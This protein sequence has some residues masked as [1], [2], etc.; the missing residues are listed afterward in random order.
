MSL[1]VLVG[2]YLRSRLMSTILN[3]FLL[4]LGITVIVFV[5]LVGRQLNDSAS[6]NSRGIDLVIAAKGSPLQIILCNVHHIDFP[7]G[8]INL[9]EAERIA[10]NSLVKKAIPL[11]L[12]DSYNG[13]RIVGTDTAYARLYKASLA[14]GD[15]WSRDLEVVAGSAAMR[16]LNLKVGDTFSS[17]H[18]LTTDGDAHDSHPYKLVGVL[19]P[20]GTVVDNLLLTNISSIWAV[21]SDGHETSVTT[22]GEESRL[23]PGVSAGDSTKEI[24]SVLIKYRNP[25]AAIQLPRMINAMTTMQAASPAF[26]MARIDSVF[27]VGVD[28][29]TGLS[30]V[31]ICISALSTFLA[32]YNA[33]KDRRYDMAIMRAMGAGRPRLFMMMILE[34]STLTVLGALLG[35]ASAHALLFA[36]TS[37][38]SELAASLN[39][40]VFYFDEVWILAGSV[41]LGFVCSLI[42]A[43][44]AARTN[45]HE[46][47]AGN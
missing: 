1:L 30:V 18:G 13:L 46:V 38:G 35:I 44:Q 34:G 12:G 19:S 22:G 25:V 9:R 39:G 7:T 37:T 20:T 47:L 21:H 10:R 43:M 4:A 15:W 36:L 32:L 23:V 28:V 27:G 3:V 41:G 2:S 14:S 33:L 17:A 31:L 8:N 45:I 5:L 6:T 42:P 29:L 26:E 24:T 11:A 16:K 40:S